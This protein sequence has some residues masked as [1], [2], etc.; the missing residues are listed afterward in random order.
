MSAVEEYIYFKL[1][2]IVLSV[3]LRD[4]G[5]YIKPQDFEDVCS[6][7]YMMYR[8][9]KVFNSIDK[10]NMPLLFSMFYIR[11][12]KAIKKL[13]SDNILVE[14]IDEIKPKSTLI[15]NIPNYEYILS[16]ISDEELELLNEAYLYEENI[17]ILAKKY[18]TSPS[19]IYGRLETIRRKLKKILED[20]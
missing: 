18:N 12:A 5:L 3:W 6:E 9:E 16:Q 19:S 15:E 8:C 4:K 17:E 10:T 2:P 11:S 20:S 13:K 14:N 7:L 1:I